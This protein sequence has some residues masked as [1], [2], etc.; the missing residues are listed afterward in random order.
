L[1]SAADASRIG[2]NDPVHDLP[3]LR[4]TAHR[5]RLMRMKEKGLF[6]NE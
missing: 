4:R 1:Q 6:K 5:S 3:S 2:A